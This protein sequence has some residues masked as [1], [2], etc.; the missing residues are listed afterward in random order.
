MKLEFP[1]MLVR[2]GTA[3][4]LET[5]RYD[6]LTVP[7]REAH[8]A[9]LAD[10]WFASQEDAI[11]AKQAEA[12]KP[13]RAELEQKATELKIKFDGRTGDAKLAEAIGAKLKG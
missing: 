5:G 13:T 10:G 7:D 6:L 12:S 3:W 11:A 2:P 8:D 1:R 9:A 4:Q